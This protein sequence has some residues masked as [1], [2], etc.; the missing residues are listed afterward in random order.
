MGGSRDLSAA[1]VD[2]YLIAAKSDKPITE[3][4]FL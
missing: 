1:V 2:A 4:T 3:V